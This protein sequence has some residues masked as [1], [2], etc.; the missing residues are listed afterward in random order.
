MAL[1]GVSVGLV[2]AALAWGFWLKVHSPDT[3]Y[4]DTARGTSWMVPGL[5][6]DAVGHN[7]LPTHVTFTRAIQATQPLS[8]RAL[9]IRV[10]GSYEV[11]L[12]GEP[13]AT[14]PA[15][16]G[17]VWRRVRRVELPE[18]ADGAHELRVVAT[19]INGPPALWARLAGED[20]NAPWTYSVNGS[21]PA[22][23]RPAED[24]WI[25]A[26][27][28]TDDVERDAVWGKPWLTLGL[29]AASLVILA[30]A[31]RAAARSRPLPPTAPLWTLAALAIVWIAL[32]AV[33]MVRLTPL[34]GY[35]VDGHLAYVEWIRTRGTLPYP[36]DG[37]QMY[38][39]PLYYLLGAGWLGL[40]GEEAG[41]ATGVRLLRALNVAWAVG[42]LVAGAF[43]IRRLVGVRAGASTIGLVFLAATPM[44]FYLY[45]YPT[46]ENLCTLMASA[47]FL[48]LAR[49][50]GH[51][52]DS[53][54]GA[55]GLGA[56]L[57]LALLSKAT[58]ILLL[59]PVVLVYLLRA[60]AQLRARHAAAARRA[61]GRLGVVLLTAAAVSG[62]H[63][64][65]IYLRYGKPIVGNWDS[66][67]GRLWWQMPGFRTWWSYV[68]DVHA[69]SRPFFAGLESV[70]SGLLTT[71]A[72][73]T[74]AA[75]FSNV[76]NRAPWNYELSAVS[77]ALCVLLAG[78]TAVGIVSRVRWRRLTMPRLDLCLLAMTIVT[79][80]L[81]VWMTLTVPAYAQ[82]KA[83][84]GLVALVPCS[85]FAARGARRIWGPA[86]DR[87]L[88]AAL[89][90]APWI[91]VLVGT[92]TI[93]PRAANVTI[94][95]LLLMD[96][97]R[98]GALEALERAV[99]AKPS[100]MN[101]RVLLATLLLPD[102]REEPRVWELIDARELERQLAAGALAPTPA[103]SRRVD[104]LSQ[105]H[106]RA[107]RTEDE[108]RLARR[109]VEL[110]PQEPHFWLHAI[111]ATSA[112]GNLEG[113]LQLA[114]DGIR[115]HP[116]MPDFPVRLAWLCE[117]AGL[118]EDA[119][120]Y[121]RLAEE[122][123]RR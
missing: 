19:R 25:G 111:D 22:Q 12:D 3:I 104:I 39:A 83:F 119:E 68:P 112:T 11:A 45:C 48:A 32:L 106:M 8:G 99:R 31:S 5:V 28:D 17:T 29:G 82:A 90:V 64:I 122:L 118:R 27:Y 30:L 63:F 74:L 15:D 86:I 79:G 53:L 77:M 58:A 108:A 101:A 55:V 123:G 94:D 33:A 70:P 69:F 24:P 103:L 41:T 85:V 47:L 98:R 2:L 72:G 9:E 76:D 110:A 50:K 35:D 117:R 44:A 13:L 91:L 54:G 6:K 61:V 43:A 109:A 96:G 38:Q 120:R 62:W 65:R 36:T 114:R 80:T 92:F 88:P 18:L 67:S 1:R 78:L 21:S 116:W 121:G 107:G 42:F 97:D 115:W 56:V 51:R 26:A 34:A 105:L 59:V 4:L 57:G 71:W 73:E 100:D 46:N 95:A 102:T 89:V 23:A 113:A 93:L 87:T 52:I 66:E 81:V 49:L 16:Q 10:L 14:S 37:W 60:A 20:S 75:G 84:Y 7:A 40:F